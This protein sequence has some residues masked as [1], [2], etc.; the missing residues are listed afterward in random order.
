M[1]GTV[2][3]TITMDTSIFEAFPNAIIT[4]LWEIGLCQHGTVVGN[5]YK[6]IADLDVIIDEGNNSSI[7]TI[8]EG[9]ASDMLVYVYPCQ[10]PTLDTSALV[11]GYMLHNNRENK[12]Y[13]IRDAGLGKNQ[14]TGNIEHLELKVVQTEVVDD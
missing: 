5:Q 7:N 9:L 13:E 14:H 3:D 2:A 12:Y 1:Q 8:P 11:S 4:G 6:K 10:M